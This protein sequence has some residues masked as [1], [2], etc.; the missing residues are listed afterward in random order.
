MLQSILGSKKTSMAA[1]LIVV[2][3]AVG[4][5]NE[6]AKAVADIV[7]VALIALGLFLSKDGDK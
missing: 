7:V 1:A 3:T 5:G 2:L 4:L 6:E